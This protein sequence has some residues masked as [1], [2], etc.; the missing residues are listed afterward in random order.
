M[1][2][3]N[4][5]FTLFET[6]VVVAI[7][8]MLLPMLFSIIFM[9]MQ[10]QLK[11]YSVTEVKRQ[12]DTMLSF[13]KN[14]VS[15]N[16]VGV[17]SNESPAN[18]VCKSSSIGRYPPSGSSI[19]TDFYFLDKKGGTFQFRTESANPSSL[20]YRIGT[21]Q[22]WQTLN[23][24]KIVISNFALQCIRKADY[25]LPLVNVSF[26]VSYSSSLIPT[27]SLHYQTII[28]LEPK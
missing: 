2:T 6:I 9:I 14:T 11:A 16:A 22:A 7:T 18:E 8:A 4:T 24:D 23:S 10:Q 25:S 28:K 13:I 26:D 19:G 20:Q 17:S 3:D 15:E 21:T 27:V 12:G 1:K 5:G